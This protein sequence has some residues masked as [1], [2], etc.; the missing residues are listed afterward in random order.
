MTQTSK[1]N[2]SEGEKVNVK[3]QKRV[4]AQSPDSDTSQ[5][6]KTDQVSKQAPTIQ[7]TRKYLGEREQASEKSDDDN[8]EEAHSRE[9][10]KHAPLT[11]SPAQRAAAKLQPSEEIAAERNDNE[12]EVATNADGVDEYGQQ[13]LTVAD[14]AQQSPPFAHEEERDYKLSRRQLKRPPKGHRHAP[15]A[16]LSALLLFVLCGIVALGIYFISQRSL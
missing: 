7:P 1:E 9:T 5:E 3:V 4:D 14:Y 15:A 11:T 2:Q 12:E 8:D 6:V 10:L 16:L 13:T